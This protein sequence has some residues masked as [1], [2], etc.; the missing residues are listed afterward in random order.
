MKFIV[1]LALQLV[2]SPL[3]Y[4]WQDLKFPL[5]KHWSLCWAID[6]APAIAL[7]KSFSQQL[8][9]CGLS[10]VPCSWLS[11]STLTFSLCLTPMYVQ[12]VVLCVQFHSRFP[13]LKYNTDVNSLL[14]KYNNAYYCCCQLLH[15]LHTSL[16]EMIKH[17]S[18]RLCLCFRIPT[19]YLSSSFPAINTLYT[20]TK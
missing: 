20:E 16:S 18:N 5:P 15:F 19:K 1:L 10:Y 9:I 12:C 2:A 17:S 7:S 4:E 6:S 3:P 8:I 11:Q 13:R 14:N